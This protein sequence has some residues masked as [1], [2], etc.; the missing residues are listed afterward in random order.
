M[1][2]GLQERDALLFLRVAG[3]VGLVLLG[4]VIES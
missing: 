2:V 4:Y 3:S 1:G